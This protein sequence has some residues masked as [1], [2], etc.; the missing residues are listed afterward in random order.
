MSEKEAV[1]MW[2]DQFGDKKIKGHNVWKWVKE[3]RKERCQIFYTLEVGK[4]ILYVTEENYTTWQLTP[5]ALK[6]IG[7]NHEC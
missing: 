4:L 5:E 7:A 6:L 1:Q 3:S 2:F